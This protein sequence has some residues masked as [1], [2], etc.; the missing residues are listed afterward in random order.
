M[1]LNLSYTDRVFMASQKLTYLQ[2][3]IADFQAFNPVRFTAQFITDYQAAILAARDYVDDETVVDGG[4]SL[5]QI[6]QEK[7]KEAQ[8]LYKIIKYFV[9]DA[10]ATN[11]GIQNK[12]GLD[13]YK[14]IR[15]TPAQMVMFL[16]NLYTQCTQYQTEL[17]AKGLNPAK[18][19]EIATLRDDLYAAVNQQATFTGERLSTTQQRK[20]LYEAM[21]IF[22]QETCRAG[23]LIYEDIDAA[24][25]QN[26]TIYQAVSNTSAIQTHNI[27]PNSTE[28]AV[29]A[30]IDDTKGIRFF[31]KG[32]NNL[33]I[34]IVGS[35]QDAPTQ[36]RAVLP[37]ETVIVPTTAISNGQYQVLVVRN[38]AGVGGKYE[39]EV[40]ESVS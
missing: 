38:S 30:G 6:V 36:S 29:S 25:F 19:T 3:D 10:F 21:D 24:K 5:T 18:I 31:N 27:S 12:F 34:Y 2:Q 37:Q 4:M 33:D 7:L 32:D 22:T 8:K 13:T 23:K 40:L 1:A 9:E 11:E 14:N 17:L 39:V 20:I 15:V 28:I 26:Y 16:S 35:L